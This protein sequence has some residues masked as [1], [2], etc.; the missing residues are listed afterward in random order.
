MYRPTCHLFCHFCRCIV[1]LCITILSSP[2]LCNCAFLPLKVS[3][4]ALPWYL[5]V[6]TY[7]YTAIS[8]AARALSMCNCEPFK[9]NFI[10][11]IFYSIVYV[12]VGNGRLQ[13]ITIGDCRPI[14]RQ[15]SET[16]QD[17]DTVSMKL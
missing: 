1:D 5:M 9:I 3:V 13:N 6:V 16:L 11:R 2:L 4:S 12:I 7:M 10:K 14:S 15:I 17:K 8:C